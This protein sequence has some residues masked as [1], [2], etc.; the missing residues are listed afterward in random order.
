M[1]VALDIPKKT[2]HLDKRYNLF[3]QAYLLIC[4]TSS[5]HDVDAPLIGSFHDTSLFEFNPF[6]SEGYTYVYTYGY[7]LTIKC[8]NVMLRN[9]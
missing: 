4:T 3:L 6:S 8:Y 5:N 2:I 7:I 9:I 1:E